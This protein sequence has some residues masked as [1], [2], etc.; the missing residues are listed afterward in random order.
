MDVKVTLNVE[1]IIKKVD[2]L[3]EQLEK[4]KKIE[5]LEEKYLILME[6]KRKCMDTEVAHVEA[7]DLLCKLLRELGMDKLVDKFEEINKWYA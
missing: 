6:E 7:D 5:K 2:G 3:K 1:E 4:L